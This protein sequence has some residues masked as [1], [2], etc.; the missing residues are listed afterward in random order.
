MVQ[1][2]LQITKAVLAAV[3]FSLACVLIFSLVTSFVSCTASVIKAVNQV[4]KILSVAFGGLLFIRG[5]RGLIKG[6]L[7]GMIAILFTYLLYGI[8]ASSLVFTWWFV[9]EL[10]LGAIAGAVSGTIGVNIKK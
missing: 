8:I 5:E 2:V 7:Y 4:L 10:L 3:I 1:H 6:A 9:L